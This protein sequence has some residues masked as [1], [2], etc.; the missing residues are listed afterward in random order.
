MDAGAQAEPLLARAG[1]DEHGGDAGDA[2]VVQVA[3]EPDRDRLRD[4]ARE[5]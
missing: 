3:N 5:R 4:L 2:R 1:E